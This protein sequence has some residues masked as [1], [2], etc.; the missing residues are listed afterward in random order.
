MPTKTVTVGS[1]VGLHA[2]PA[3]VISEAVVNAGVPVL[4][5]VDLASAGSGFSWNDWMRPSGSAT[6]MP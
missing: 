1:A 3:A 2:R 6:T 5:R 4:A